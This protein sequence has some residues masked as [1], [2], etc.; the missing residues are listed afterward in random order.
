MHNTLGLSGRTG[1]VKDEQRI[2]RVHF[3]RFAVFVRFGHQFLVPDVAA[4]CK[5]NLRSG[6]FHNHHGLHTGALSHGFVGCVFLRNGLGAAI[7][8]VAGD[9]DFRAGVINAV[10]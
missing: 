1:G 2:F 10:S 4:F 5:G 3:F 8:A 7:G 6:A 9:D